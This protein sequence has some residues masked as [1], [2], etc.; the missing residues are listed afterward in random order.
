MVQAPMLPVQQVR[1]RGVGGQ[2]G[3]GD[4]ELAAPPPTV[5]TKAVAGFVCNDLEQSRPKRVPAG[6]GRGAS[7]L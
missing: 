6:T 7:R 2:I 4:C 1:F 3:D 5:S